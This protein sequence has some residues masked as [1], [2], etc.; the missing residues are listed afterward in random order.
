MIGTIASDMVLPFTGQLIDRVPL[1]YYTAFVVLLLAISSAFMAILPSVIF[2]L[3]A[4]FLLRQS[5][6]GLMSHT[7]FVSMARYFPS[8]RGKAAAIASLGLS[9]GQAT[10]PF[11]MI[12]LVSVIGWRFSYGLISIAIILIILPIFKYV[13]IIKIY[14]TNCN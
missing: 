3:L 8:S 12:L 9:V 4:I 10:L 7:S 6:Q 5:G 11:L 2:L 1:T 13:S 14:S